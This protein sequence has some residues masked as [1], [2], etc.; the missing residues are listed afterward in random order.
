MVATRLIKIFFLERDLK[1]KEELQRVLTKKGLNDINWFNKEEECLK[2]LEHKPDF[3]FQDKVEDNTGGYTL[4]YESKKKVPHSKFIFVCPDK[5]KSFGEKGLEIG[6]DALYIV[7]PST[8]ENFASEVHQ[9]VLNE[10]FKRF[11]QSVNI[12]ML[13]FFAII[14]FLLIIIISV[15]FLNPS[16]F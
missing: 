5:Y 1:V 3:I 12:G 7:N 11:N 13:E 8:Y 15:V 9:M 4:F 6:A 14:G 16:I 10:K 2:Q